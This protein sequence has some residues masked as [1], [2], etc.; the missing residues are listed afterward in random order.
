M[1]SHGLKKHAVESV[2]SKNYFVI[3]IAW[4][5]LAFLIAMFNYTDKNARKVVYFFLIYFGFSFVNKS[6]YVDAYRYA[7]NFKKTAALPFSDFSV[8]IGGLYSDST[9]DII[10]PLSRFFLSRFTDNPAV[11]FA[12]WVAFMGFFY[13]KSIGL[14]YD[15]YKTNPTW[16][17]RLLLLLFIFIIPITAVSGIRMPTA[18]FMF[19]FSS[20]YIVLYRDKRFIPLAIFSCLIHWSLIIANGVL[21]IYILAGNRNVIYLPI[22]ILSFVL[23]NLLAPLFKTLASSAGG[24][25]QSRYKGYSHEGYIA[26]IQDSYQGASWF[27]G[28]HEDLVLYFLLFSIVYIQVKGRSLMKFEPEKNLFSFLLLFLSFINFADIIP[29]FGGRFKIV[30]FLYA[31]LYV[32]IYTTR[33][34]TTMFNPIK[35]ASIFPIALYCAVQFRLGSEHISAWIIYPVLGLS[36]LVQDLSLSELIF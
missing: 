34:K 13:L 27:L 14:V 15:K 7:A 36:E 26:S 33:V 16:T 2:S 32:L 22:T 20:Y 30:Y 18:I 10:E 8:I 21:F 3:F 1:Q 12:F 28:L 25:F 4:P 24:V 35:L 6:V 5:L 17:S 9:A 11:F 19:F 29:S 31:T 23:P